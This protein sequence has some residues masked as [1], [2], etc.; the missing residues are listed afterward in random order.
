MWWWWLGG[1]VDL[2]GLRG[3][4]DPGRRFFVC[5]VPSTDQSVCIKNRTEERE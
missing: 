4:G 5:V 1:R 3:E 2:G